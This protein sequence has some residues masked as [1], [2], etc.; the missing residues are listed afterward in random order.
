LSYNAS[1]NNN[2]EMYI[3]AGFPKR[4]DNWYFI[5]KLNMILGKSLIKSSLRTLFSLS[6][7]MD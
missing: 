2:F 1:I 6:P 3:F 7:V 4:K 5:T